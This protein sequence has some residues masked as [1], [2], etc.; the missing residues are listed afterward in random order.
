MTQRG[1]APS[2][3][4][5]PIWLVLSMWFP[6]RVKKNVHAKVPVESSSDVRSATEA[7]CVAGEP[8]QGG[9]GG[10]PGLLWRLQAVG[11]AR[12]MGYLPGRAT[13]REVAER[14]K[15]AAVSKAGRVWPSQ[16]FDMRHG[17]A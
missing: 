8:V 17:A 13:H 16:L 12:A 1:Q 11:D 6:F 4:G 7:R 3:A 10:E 15:Y 2:R 9:C 14:E 5:R